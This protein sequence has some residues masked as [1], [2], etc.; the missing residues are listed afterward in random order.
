M[1]YRLLIFLGLWLVSW[2]S[3]QTFDPSNPKAFL[4][5]LGGNPC[6][7]GFILFGIVA[8]AKRSAE[9]RQYKAK[10]LVWK[11]LAF[12][13]GLS[14]S[15]LLHAFAGTAVLL[16]TGWIGAVLFGVNAGGLAIIGRDGFKTI[17]SWGAAIISAALAP[18]FLTSAPA[19]MSVPVPAATPVPSEPS[20][21][22]RSPL[23]LP[24]PPRPCHRPPALRPPRPRLPLE[25]LP[26][27]P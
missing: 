7:L 15:L 10:P 18:G 4:D 25:I 21:A 3:A 14:I 6:Y 12:S 23:R 17:I 8:S 22:P 11:L 19:A 1:L 13:S 5:I 9:R 16:M 27:L 2:A 20:Q 26:C 24:S